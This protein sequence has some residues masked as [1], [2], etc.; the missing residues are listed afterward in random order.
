MLWNASSLQLEVAD[1]VHVLDQFRKLEGLKFKIQNLKVVWI[2]PLRHTLA[3][4]AKVDQAS[5]RQW[6]NFVSDANK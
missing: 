1:S 5:L 6:L 2:L 3:S 4:W